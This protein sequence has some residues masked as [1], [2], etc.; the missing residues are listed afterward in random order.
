MTGPL[1]LLVDDDLPLRHSVAEQL[2]LRGLRVVQAGT[3]AEAEIALAETRNF[4]AILLDTGLPDGDGAALCVRW[5]GAGL[6]CPVILLGGHPVAAAN[7]HLAKPFRLGQLLGRLEVLLRRSPPPPSE[8]PLVL[9]P[10]LFHPADRLLVRA[11]DGGKLRLTE[12][13]AALL[14]LLHAAGGA[15]VARETLLEQVWGY[16]DG[17]T[18]HTLETH[19]YRL[20]RKIESDPAEARLLLTEPGGYRLAP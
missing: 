10:Y 18:T 15:G 7:D 12:K 8:P 20:R 5:R 3:V 11:A 14:R 9:G 13:E 4:A 1:I 19:I 6:A 2:D 17:I 16:R